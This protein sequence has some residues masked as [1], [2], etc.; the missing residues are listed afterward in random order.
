[1]LKTLF[2]RI[3][4]VPQLGATQCINLGRSGLKVSRICLG[5]MSFGSPEWQAWTIPEDQSRT[6]IRRALE[7]GINFFDTADV[8][9]TGLSETILGRALADFA[10]RDQIVLAT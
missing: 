10:R 9:S 3:P 8:Y 5:T 4:A 6:I 2:R 7:L 1:M